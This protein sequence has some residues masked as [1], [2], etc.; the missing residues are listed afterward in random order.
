M[1]LL[2][3]ARALVLLTLVTLAGILRT[4]RAARLLRY[5]AG[6]QSSRREGLP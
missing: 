5:G 2:R 4:G 1:R 3:R 6:P